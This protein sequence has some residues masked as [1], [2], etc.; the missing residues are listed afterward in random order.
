M[1]S[2]TQYGGPGRTFDSEQGR[3]ASGVNWIVNQDIINCVLEDHEIKVCTI[4]NPH[5]GE[6]RHRN[7]FIFADDM[8][9]LA[10][11][12]TE[13]QSIETICHNLNT[14]GQTA[15]DCMKAPGGLVGLPKCSWRCSTPLYRQNPRWI[16][17]PI[18]TA[19]GLN[20]QCSTKYNSPDT[21]ESTP[22][23]IRSPPC[24]IVRSK[25]SNTAAQELEQ[26][27]QS[28]PTQESN[29]CPP[30]CYHIRTL[31]CAIHVIPMHHPKYSNID[32]WLPA[33]HHTQSNHSKAFNGIHLRP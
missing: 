14:I 30:S 18:P 19:A 4:H 20:S 25:T 1:T 26:G 16:P 9:F 2:A 32:N 15:S 17:I 27:T 10:M 33:E 12:T 13:E 6:I 11:S 5:S 31:H 21:I 28:D 29:H 24:T 3:G 23:P 8:N 7:A 22:P